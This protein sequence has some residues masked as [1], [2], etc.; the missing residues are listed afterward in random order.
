MAQR[1]YRS[2]LSLFLAFRGRSLTVAAAAAFCLAASAGVHAQN[3]ASEQRASLEVQRLAPQLVDFA[4]S[5]ANFDSLVRG[6]SEGLPVSLVSS[7]PDGLTQTV[8]FTPSTT[9]SS[10]DIARTLE[11]A[12]QQLIARGIGA[13]SAEQIGVTLVGGALPTALGTT[14]VNGV[15]PAQS[16]SSAQANGQASAG[17]STAPGIV[18]ARV[19]NAAADLTVSVQPSA[20]ASAAAGASTDSGTLTR[21]PPRFTS[22]STV[23]GN[24]SDSPIP[25]PVINT[26]A[27]SLGAIPAAPGATPGALGASPRTAGANGPPSPAAQ[28]QGRR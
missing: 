24:T 7:T 27:V 21:I 17:A 20:P 11:Q 18:P 28:M 3:L 4:G 10:L 16:A 25:A 5:Q 15:L 14:A 8:T 1:S 12:R 22:D 23:L 9:L 19:P 13:P 2:T 26:P 6:L